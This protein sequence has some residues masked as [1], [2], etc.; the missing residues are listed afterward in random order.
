MLG[1][2]LL[3]N[4]ELRRLA[5]ESRARGP[6]TYVSCAR[7][8]PVTTAERFPGESPFHLTMVHD[9]YVVLALTHPREPVSFAAREHRRADGGT[10]LALAWLG[11]EDGLTAS[12]AASF[13]T[14]EGMPEDGF[15]R[16]EVYGAGWAA[17]VEA[18]PRPLALWDSRARSPLT[19]EISAEGGAPAG[20]LAEELRCFCRVVRGAQSVPVGASY[21]DAIRIERWLEQIERAAARR[22]GDDAD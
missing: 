22:G 13:L 21:H 8:R 18:N 15:D 14:P 2:I 16:M 17:R 10:D 11:W 7:H 20:M 3:F 12:F 9:L 5:A 1:H 4:T 19:L 6:L